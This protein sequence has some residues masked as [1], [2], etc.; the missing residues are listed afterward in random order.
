MIDLP[1]L[2]PR[3]LF[4]YGSTFKIESYLAGALVDQVE[5][6]SGE[7]DTTVL[8]ALGRVAVVVTCAIAKN[9]SVIDPNM[10]E[11]IVVGRL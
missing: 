10:I 4:R 7:L 11:R 9:V 2:T 5:G 6:V 1:W 8:L 3:I